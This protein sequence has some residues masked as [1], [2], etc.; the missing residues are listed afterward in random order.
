MHMYQKKIVFQIRLVKKRTFRFD[1]K[2]FFVKSWQTFV[3][4]FFQN[5]QISIII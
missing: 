3:A 1:R 2:T 5:I 4:K